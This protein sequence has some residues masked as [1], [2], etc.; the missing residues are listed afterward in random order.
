MSTLQFS[1][2]LG[3]PIR[4]DRPADLGRST[5]ALL[6]EALARGDTAE[7]RAYLDYL[8]QERAIIRQLNAVFAWHLAKYVLDRQGEGFWPSLVEQTLAPWIT[9]SAGIANSPQ[10]M[11]STTPAHGTTGRAARVTAGSNSFDVVEQDGQ[12]QIAIGPLPEQLERWTR[13][14]QSLTTLLAQPDREEISRLLA[15][16]LREELIVH[17]IYGD[18]DWA[19]M[20]WICRTWGEAG[21]GDVLRITQDP[22]LKPR[23]QRVTQMTAEESL[24]LSV[25]G[26][27]G[28]FAGPGRTGELTVVDEPDRYVMSFDACGSGGRMRRGDATTDSPSRLGPPYNFLN[29]DEAYPWTWSRKGVCAYCAHCAMALQIMPIE[30]LGHPMRVTEYPENADDPCRWIVYKKPEL[31]PDEAYAVVG[32]TPPKRR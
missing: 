25:E 14:R 24:Q 8:F 10:A 28:H 29:L 18:W 11:V 23:Y 17:D 22:W 20:S 6:D 9:A 32:K 31:I 30:E 21:F 16:Q 3:R 4:Q 19:L 5:G 26:M 2:L 27:R 1:Q 7:A 13:R 15:E 12:Y